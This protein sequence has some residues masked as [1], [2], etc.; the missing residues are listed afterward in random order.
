MRVHVLQHVPF[1]GLGHIDSWLQTQGAVTTL[2]CFHVSPELPP[3]TGLDLVIALGGPMSVNDAARLPWL[4]AERRFIADAIAGKVAVLGLCLGAQ[5]MA[6]ALGARV[7]RNPDREIGWYPVHAA[8]A[9]PGHFVFPQ[10]LLAF[11]WHGETFDLPAGAV[12]LARS[13]GCVN[14]AFQFGRRAIGLQFHLETT[15]SAAAALVTHC[16]HELSPGRY[17][18]SAGDILSAAPERYAAIR[19]VMERVLAY[20]IGSEAHSRTDGGR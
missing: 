13:N 10:E 20:L 11:H 6:S 3:V 17:V 9:P 2:T 18:Q 19:T 16:G 7:F 8:P 4:V 14:Q 12:H 1:E 15:P 5:L